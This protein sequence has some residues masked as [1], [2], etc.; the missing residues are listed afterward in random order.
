MTVIRRLLMGQGAKR[1]LSNSS[2]RSRY[3]FYDLVCKTPTH[4]RE[5]IEAVLMSESQLKALRKHTKTTYEGNYAMDKELS[6]EERIA[7][8]FGGRIKGESPRAT[9][10]LNRG[11]PRIIAGVTVPDKP[12]EPDNCCMS[13]CANCVWEI[14][15]ED[16]K[17]WNDKRKEAAA[18][19]KKHGG[20]WP[21][22]FHAPIKYLAKENLPESLLNKGYDVDKE[23]STQEGDEM[24]GNVPVS[25]RVFAETEKRLKEKHKNR[26]KFNNRES[27]AV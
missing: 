11:E 3:D 5:P 20:R 15:N 24:W 21:E 13:G 10:R 7:K 6:A 4:P 12:P 9:S 26:L 14:F 19:L 1:A 8:V 17:Y 25:I 22:D 23:K 16:V 27:V 18:K 2:V